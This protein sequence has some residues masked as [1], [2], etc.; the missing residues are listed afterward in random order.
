MINNPSKYQKII[1]SLV[2]R[3]PYFLKKIF[4]Y[5]DDL[6]VAADSE[7]ELLELVNTVVRAV[8]GRGGT[9]K[10]T[11]VR[12][13]YHREVVLGSESPGGASDPARRTSRPSTGSRCR[14]TPQR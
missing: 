6:I 7:A 3:S 11:K 10:P 2:N 14:P 8:A 12:I 4:V 5:M 1:E 13:G 9:L